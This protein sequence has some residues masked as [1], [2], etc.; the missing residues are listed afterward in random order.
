MYQENHN[1]GFRHE[2]WFYDDTEQYLSWL[3]RYAVL[4]RLS[5]EPLLLAVPGDR[6]AALRAR[7]PAEGVTFVDLYAQGRNPGRI[8]ADILT[9]FMDEH[10][11]RR[12]NIV[13]E[14]MWKERSD[15]AY[16]AVVEHEALT[17]L[18]FSGRDAGLVCAYDRASLTIDAIVDA[19]ETHPFVRDGGGPRPS[20]AY[21]DPLR[22]ATEAIGQPSPPP[23]D[24]SSAVFYDLPMVRGVVREEAEH[25]RMGRSRAAD[26]TT[27]VNE[28]ATNSLRH[29]GGAGELRL[30]RDSGELVV[31]V[32]DSG[33]IDDPLVG[34]RAPT[35][36][37]PGR[38][39]AVAHSLCDLMQVWRG[40]TG[41]TVRMW[42]A[43]GE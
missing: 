25:A 20:R 16:A 34:R 12:V 39:L 38:G 8:I 18:A 27:A 3:T 30:W 4:A 21:A 11:D 32:R 19:H 35:D 6:H 13:S 1:E 9:R 17:N 2:A 40:R 36:A 26:I 24:A 14:P 28:V 33:R 15:S 7:L 10:A 22:M 31:E 41:T 43:V 5:R 29:G 42:V 23:P 37:S